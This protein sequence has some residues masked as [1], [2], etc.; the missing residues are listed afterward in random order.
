MEVGRKMYLLSMLPSEE[1]VGRKFGQ[2]MV[3]NLDMQ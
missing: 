3:Q 2:F 1:M